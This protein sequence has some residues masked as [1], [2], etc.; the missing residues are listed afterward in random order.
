MRER[1]LIVGASIAG[2]TAAYWLARHGFEP[3]VIEKASGPRSGGNGVD[4]RGEAVAVADAMGI[5]HAV[6]RSAADVLG[7]KFIDGGGRTIARVR[8][9]DAGDVEVMRGDLVALLAELAPGVR[10]GDSPVGIEQDSSGVRVRFESGSVDRFAL[11]IGADGLHSTVR[12]LVFGGEAEFLRFRDH[13]FAFGDADASLGEDRW[14]TMYNVP[15]KMAGIYRS[16][17]HAQAKSYFTFRSS[18]STSEH[19]DARLT[20]EGKRRM[21]A[22]AFS[23]VTGWR[24]PELLASVL[25]GDGLY[26]D[27]LAQVRMPS[28]ARGRVVLVGDAAWCASPA[29]GAGAELAIVGAYRLANSVAAADDDWSAALARYESDLRTRVRRK[30]RIGAN[31][32]LMVPATRFGIAARNAFARSGLPAVLSGF[33]A[34]P[35]KPPTLPALEC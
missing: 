13:Y 21:L 35:T 8:T 12:R 3:V 11:V 26:F 19:G 32:R 28:W 10:F 22:E 4:L 9:A 27:A 6:Q 17:H 7:M 16:G 23:D 33:G 30:Q 18:L 5:L 1:I 2:L 14:V 20:V 15:G 29:A 25:A 34:G 31:V 24:T